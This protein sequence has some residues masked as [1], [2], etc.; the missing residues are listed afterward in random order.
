M[1]QQARQE[2][3]Y[4]IPSKGT[5]EFCDAKRFSKAQKRKTSNFLLLQRAIHDENILVVFFGNKLVEKDTEEYE[6]L[7][8]QRYAAVNIHRGK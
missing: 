5:L 6:T 1:I 4:L 2:G 3:K 8:E 7:R